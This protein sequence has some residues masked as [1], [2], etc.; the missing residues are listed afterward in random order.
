MKKK[1]DTKYLSAL[2]RVFSPIVMDSLSQ[3]G[4]SSY[5]TEVCAN[6]GLLEKIDSSMT[7]R[8]FLDWIYNLLFKNYRNEYIYKNVI[9]NKILLGK[10]SLNTSHMLTEFRVG[11]CKAD[12]VILN[13]T[14]TVYEIKS[15]Y[16]SFA[17]LE[18]QIQ[19]YFE[20]FEFIN[21]ITA[22]SQLEKLKSILPE[23]V[24]ILSLTKRKT[25]ATIREAKSNMVNINAI[26]LFDSFRKPEYLKIIKEYYGKIPD[27]P[28]TQIH[29][30]CKKLFCE[31]PPVDSHYLTIKT[32]RERSDSKVLKEFIIKY[33]MSL[34]A[35][36]MS[37]C[38][39][40]KKMQK[41]MELL[42]EN[43]Y[44]MLVSEFI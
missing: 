38:N 4:Y 12:V 36:A 10:H 15:E 23:K 14:S 27:V 6:C 17:R 30:V 16:D 18:K 5:L 42:D 13:G 1:I 41:I 2:G 11:K 44:S 35:Y 33:P 21:V 3:K 32:F 20:I 28:N 26:T 31:I 19:T 43:I 24:G 25:I 8:Q 22:P 39:E 34:T 40:K 7:L 29:N 9:A 37:I